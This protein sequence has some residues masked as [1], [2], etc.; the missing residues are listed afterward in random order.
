MG[1]TP[2][3]LATITIIRTHTR[4]SAART[5]TTIRIRNRVR[6]S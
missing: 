2:M 3:A 4:I 1:T 5:V 6:C